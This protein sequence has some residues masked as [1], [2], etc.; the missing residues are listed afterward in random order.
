[1]TKSLEGSPT[2]A[3][4]APSPHEVRLAPL[5]INPVFRCLQQFMDGISLLYATILKSLVTIGIVIVEN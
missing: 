5:D 2:K 3:K 4:E 1:M